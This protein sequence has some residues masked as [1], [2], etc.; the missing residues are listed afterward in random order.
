MKILLDLFFLKTLFD[1]YL[2]E[3][4]NKRNMKLFVEIFEN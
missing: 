4:K 2:R 3:P 1:D